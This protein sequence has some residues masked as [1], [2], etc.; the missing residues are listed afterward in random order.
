MLMTL[1]IAT[2]WAGTVE[3]FVGGAVT[4]GVGVSPDGAAL[5]NVQA[6]IDLRAVSE[7]VSAR[8]DIDGKFGFDT[9]TCDV[10]PCVVQPY[11]PE[12]AMIQVG[13]TKGY[14]RAGVTNPAIG[15]EDWDPWVNP[16]PT[17]SILFG[18][19]SPGRNAGVEVGM[20]QSN[21][22]DT[23]VWFGYDLEWL[24]YMTG[25][26][27]AYSGD[28]FGTWSG[29]VAYPLADGMMYSTFLSG[30]VYPSEKLTLILDG[31]AGF[32]YGDAFGGAQ[33]IASFAINDSVGING[34]VEAAFD[35]ND[36]FA[37]YADQTAGIG[38]TV[39]PAEFVRFDVETKAVVTDGEISPLLHAQLTLVRE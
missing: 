6:E 15:Y 13:Q 17:Y 35:A 8:F 23:F 19:A 22:A 39:W 36:A 30:E 16:L 7:V 21:G 38:V 10:A 37:G 26:G 2:A 3:T 31:G 1:W 27:V 9:N 25:A 34:R 4:A 24:E 20:Y 5:D 12:W 29:I 33:F 32:I 11:P 28:N 14:V 18:A